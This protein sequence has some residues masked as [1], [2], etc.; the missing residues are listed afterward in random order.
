[1]SKLF[2]NIM[3]G[4]AAL[5]LSPTVAFADDHGDPDKSADMTEGEKKLADL[6]KGRVAG[7]P[8]DCIS[9]MSTV[10]DMKVIDKTAIVFGRGKTIYVNYTRYPR[11]I[12]DSDILVIKRTEASRL[13]RLD[14]VTTMDRSTHMFSGVVFL[15]D[16]IPYT[17]E[18]EKSGN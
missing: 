18:E 9:T 10:S 16:F 6:L 4:A 2:R 11:T 17:R 12:D 13:C 3:L 7:K 1:M 14:N 8:V 15:S 5:A